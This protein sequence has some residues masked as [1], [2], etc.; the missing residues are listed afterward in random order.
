LCEDGEVK[1]KGRYEKAIIQKRL[2]KETADLSALTYENAAEQRQVR[3]RS[4]T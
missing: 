4:K 1:G 3:E 2:D